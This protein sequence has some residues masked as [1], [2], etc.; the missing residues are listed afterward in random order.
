MIAWKRAF[1]VAIRTEKSV[2]AILIAAGEHETGNLS[3]V[4]IFWLN[5]I[6]TGGDLPR[7]ASRRRRGYTVGYAFF[8]ESLR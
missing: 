7:Y 3:M 4:N 6:M 5:A 8:R 2:A 1:V